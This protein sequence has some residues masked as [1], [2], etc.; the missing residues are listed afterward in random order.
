M[1]NQGNIVLINIPFSDLKPVKKRPVLIV[2][3]DEY[4]NKQQDIIV[5]AITSNIT[6]KDY[7]AEF[8]NTDM[9]Q[10]TIIKKSCV[11]ADKILS[12]DKS[13]VIKQF[14]TVSDDIMTK[15]INLIAD[16]ISNQAKTKK[17]Q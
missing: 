6:T 11:R 7:V 2:S 14:G 4:N 8:D 9:K 16:V 17:S 5:V 12:L 3:K 15:T 1:Y 13:L 10:G